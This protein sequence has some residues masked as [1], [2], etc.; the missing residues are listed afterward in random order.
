MTDIHPQI[1][2][3]RTLQRQDRRLTSL[4]RKLGGIPAR[5]S[6]LDSDLQK[7]EQL[8]VA[9]RAKLEETK[10]FQSR[11]E[12]QL[13]DEEDQIRNSKAKLGQIKTA[14]ELNAQQRELETTRRMVTTRTGEI[15]KLQEAVTRTEQQIAKMEAHLSAL[16][17]AAD[18]EKGRLAEEQTQLDESIAKARK[19]RGKSVAAID[20]EILANYERIRKRLGGLAFVPAHRERCTACKMMIPHILYTRLLKGKEILPC[21]SCGRL[22]YWSGHFPEDQDKFEADNKPKPAEDVIPGVPEF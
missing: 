12:T 4:E 15:S 9:E 16:R 20:K 5:I 22:L 1:P 6:G 3:L 18:A 11:Q 2:A 10:N 21:E 14:R 7:L 19:L 8:L 13:H 17:A